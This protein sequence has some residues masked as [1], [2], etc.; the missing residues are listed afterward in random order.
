MLV[1]DF[2]IHNNNSSWSISICAAI[3]DAQIQQGNATRLV[4][5]ADTVGSSNRKEI[6]SLI[7]WADTI[8]YHRFVAYKQ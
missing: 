6:L 1:E 7:L 5:L 3:L 4:S 2:N 8:Q